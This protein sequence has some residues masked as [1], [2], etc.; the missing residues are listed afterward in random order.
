MIT[1][2]IREILIMMVIITAAMITIVVLMLVM[3]IPQY[4]HHNSQKLQ[5]NRAIR[6]KE[7]RKAATVRYF[8]KTG[9]ENVEAKKRK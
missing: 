1:V 8:I 5:I 4:F 9:K 2:E 7:R 3:I 6:Y